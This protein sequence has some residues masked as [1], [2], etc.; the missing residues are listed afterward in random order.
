MKKVLSLL[1]IA[2]MFAFVACGDEKKD[3][4]DEKSNE[5]KTEV[6]ADQDEVVDVPAEIVVSEDMQA[7]MDMF[8]GTYEQ[9]EAAL[10][11]YG[12]TDEIMEDDMG[13]YDMSEPVVTAADGDCFTFEAKAGMTKR[14]YNMCWTEGKITSI[15]FVEMI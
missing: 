8:D 10:Q 7:F 9:V 4:K 14:I 6:K 15:E 1:M 5:Q 13:M 2:A 3:E 12:A 11:M